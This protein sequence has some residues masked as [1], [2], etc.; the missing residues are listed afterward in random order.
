MRE[1]TVTENDG[2]QRLDKYLIKLMPKLP[3]SMMYKGL[4]K[5]CVRINGK[6]QKDGAVYV[7]TGDVIALYFS[8]EFFEE[9]RDF[10]YVKPNFTVIY[11]DDNIII[12]DKPVGVLS[13][14]DDKGRGDTL[15]DMIKSY[16]YDK[17]EYLP[18]RENTFSPALCNRLDRN[19]GGLVIAAKNASSLRDV[20]ESIRNRLIKKYYT[21][22]V[23]GDVPDCGHLEN[24][25]VRSGKI[26]S[27]SQTG[28]SASLDYKVISRIKG[29][30]LVSINLHTGRTHQIRAQFADIG[31]PLAG[32]TK[33]GGD[34][35]MF[36]QSLYSTKL[37]LNFDKNSNLAYLNNRIIE[38]KAPFESEF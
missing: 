13:H 12:V 16:L 2:G 20:N 24:K 5:N 7:G 35:E 29:Y 34:G 15:I 11:E 25:L 30:A 33:Y 31:C 1:F 18:Q 27:V 28:K 3:K 36:R 19:T 38:I 8:D 26:T 17:G 21:A 9:K 22:V 32:D 4:R 23:T 10:K 6:H 37:V 14:A